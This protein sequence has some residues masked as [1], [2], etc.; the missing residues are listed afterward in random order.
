MNHRAYAEDIPLILP[1]YYDYPDEEAAYHVPNEYAFGSEMI[2]APVTTPRIAGL[3]AAKT[4]VWLP[5]G[6]FFDIFTGRK[7]RGNR[8]ITMYR[9]INSIPVLA[10]AGAVIPTACDIHDVE[11]NPEELCIH[12]YAGAA[13]SFT[14]YEDDN[15]S[16]EYK[17]GRCATTKMHFLWGK[18]AEFLIDGAKGA[19]D[20]IPAKRT[21]V[22]KIHGVTP[23]AD[24][25][26]LFVNGFD[27]V[28][29]GL[30]VYDGETRT[31]TCTLEGIPSDARV[32]ILITDVSEAE[33]DIVKE[34]FD[35]LNQAEISF[36]LKDE[37]YR[38]IEAASDRTVLLSQL[39]AME[40]DRD[41]FGALTEIISA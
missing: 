12:V 8:N 2:V 16:E 13:G 20:L 17:N 5:D 9:G 30:A 14:L 18:D 32:R 10:K 31:L 6:T 28:P 7:Y 15:V 4:K 29:D 25:T 36:V 19:T 22:V 21:Y 33:N 11:T 23:C 27:D 38:L 39:A 1:M 34:A 26:S 40:L 41:L 35:F 37:L 3:N 24:R